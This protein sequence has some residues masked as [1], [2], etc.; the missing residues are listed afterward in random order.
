[1]K[2]KTY[3]GIIENQDLVRIYTLYSFL[4][5]TKIVIYGKHRLNK[6]SFLNKNIIIEEDFI[7]KVYSAWYELQKFLT[8]RSGFI[9]SLALEKNF[10][11]RLQC[12]LFKS[13]K[14]VNFYKQ[15]YANIQ[16]LLLRD[17]VL[18][19]DNEMDVCFLLPFF[20][21]Y[22]VLAKEHLKSEEYSFSFIITFLYL[23]TASRGFI[24][25]IIKILLTKPVF[26]KR[27]KFRVLKRLAWGFHGKDLRDDM[28]VDNIQIKK[29]DI[30]FFFESFSIKKNEKKIYEEAIKSGYRVILIDKNFNINQSFFNAIRNNFLFPIVMYLPLLLFSPFL[31]LSS[32]IFNS[33][34]FTCAKLFSFVSV[35]KFWSVGNWHDI[36]ETVVANNHNTRTFMY[37]WSDYA[38][39]YLHPFIYTVQDDVFMWGTLE[40]K[41]MIQRSMHEN[42]YTIGCLFSNSIL[43]NKEKLYSRLG[44]DFKKP[45]LA[46]YD[47][48]VSNS[49]RF[50]QS[51]FDEFREIILEIEK[52]YPNIQIVVK[53]KKVNDEYK[54]FFK[55]TSIKLFDSSDISLGDIVN[56]ASIN[57]GMGFVAPITV[58]IIMD[59]VGLI[60]DTAGNYHN[61]LAKYQGSI[62]FRNK[63]KL[64]ERIDEI[65]EHGNFQP[66]PVE[67]KLGYNIPKTDPID[68]LRTY[69][70]NNVVDERYR[71]ID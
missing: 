33:K 59:R 35:D 29:K 49:M 68:I 23:L 21:T 47:S 51:L 57:I 69:V 15:Y 25:S 6:F 5:R 44:L 64:I 45:L 26:K 38:Q 2:S 18:A 41:F 66:M 70:S 62:V 13:D 14:V 31:L 42:M 11:L 1:M 12:W 16:Y 3:I 55:N 54:H 27:N 19:K 32:R 17:K 34:S 8:L 53:P 46:F 37:S 7:G 10:F 30:V 71:L 60:F 40:N 67:E 39:S 52:K 43:E 56:I 61:P 20:K 36:A 9:D 58:S 4:F 28:L 24:G 48:P 22:R 65:I 50:P 63:K